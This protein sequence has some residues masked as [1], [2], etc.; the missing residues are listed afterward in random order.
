MD[1]FDHALQNR[2]QTE[3]PLAERMRPRTLDE[4]G[5]I[6]AHVIF[7]SSIITFASRMI[8]G[9]NRYRLPDGERLDDFGPVM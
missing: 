5:A 1:L 4:I 8:F 6:V 2:M 9:T 3:A 7:V